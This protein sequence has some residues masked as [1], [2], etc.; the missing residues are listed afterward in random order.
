M[1]KNLF[2]NVTNDEIKVLKWVLKNEGSC[3]ADYFF[4]DPSIDGRIEELQKLNFINVDDSESLSI[5]ELGR[6]AL[7]EYAYIKRNKMLSIIGDLVKFLV[8]TI[9]SILA[10]IVSIIALNQKL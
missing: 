1:S 3:A 4:I 7:N 6:A 5:T 10:L 9:I 8:P 2:E